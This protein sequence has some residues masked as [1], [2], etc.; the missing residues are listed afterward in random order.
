VQ[1]YVYSAPVEASM[2]FSSGASVALIV[3]DPPWLFVDFRAVDARGKIEI[4]LLRMNLQSLLPEDPVDLLSVRL[5][6]PFL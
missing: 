4:R 1:P 6:G 5:R 2:V 3:P